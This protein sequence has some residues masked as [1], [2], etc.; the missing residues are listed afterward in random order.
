MSFLKLEN[1]VAGYEKKHPILTGFNLTI[2]QGELVSLLGPSG[3]GKT[4][5]LRTVAGFLQPTEGR[6]L[7]GGQDYTR[8]PP[9]KRN[10]G[11]VFQ[12]YALFPHLSVARNV[13]FGLRMRRRPRAEIRERVQAALERV[14]MAG[15]EDRLPS[16]LSGGQQQRVALARAIVI[17]PDLLLLDEPL[18]NLDA[19]LRVEMRAELRRLQKDLGITML[20]VTHDQAEALS[21]SDRIV[22]MNAGQIEQIGA[23]RDIYNRPATAFVA[24]FM[25][26][27]NHFQAQVQAAE[28]ERVTVQAGAL[29]LQATTGDAERVH[30]GDTVDV[31]FRPT[32][33]R[34]LHEDAP[35]AIPARYEFLTFQGDTLQYLVETALG[36]FSV[37]TP[38]EL[39][40][41]DALRVVVAPERLIVIPH[42]GTTHA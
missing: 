28:G 30:V 37:I 18:S 17:E 1:V 20:Y 40:H 41:T 3:C 14:G 23:P 16:Q 19:K 4:T 7:L 26:F 39:P 12:N 29:T 35:N 5:T 9:H 36:H 34:L 24:R 2:A 11:L 13:A 27:D 32:Q 21:L 31:F 10:I 15:F 22:V 42:E 8:R 6:V 38:E 25:G 33:A